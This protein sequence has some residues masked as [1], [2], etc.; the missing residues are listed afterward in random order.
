[1]RTAQEFEQLRRQATAPRLAG[2]SRREIKQV[3]GPISYRTLDKA[4]KEVPPAEWTRRPNAKDDLRARARELRLQGLDYD[5]IVSLRVT[6]SNSDPSLIR[7]FLCFLRIAGTADGDVKFQLQIHDSV[8]VPAAEAYWLRV[9]G[10]QPE[11]FRRTVLK[12]SN[13]QTTRRNTGAD[14]HGC[15]RIDVLQSGRLYLKIDGWAGA[16]MA[17][18]PGWSDPHDSH[19]H[20]IVAMSKYWTVRHA[21]SDAERAAAAAQF[22]DL[23]GRELLIAGAIAYWCEGSKRKPYRKDTQV[24]FINSDPR[25]ILLFLRF[26]TEAGVMPDRLRYCVHIH[27]SADVEAAISWWA[28]VA[29]VPPDQFARPVIKRHT[30][31]TAHR[32]ANHEYHG[33]LQI[34]VRKGAALYRQIAGWATGV[35]DAAP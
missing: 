27:E 33:C 7:L 2:K 1:M 6:F 17:C 20:A 25:L 22:S 10:A 4:L 9:T 3:L 34:R 28:S 29:G 18:A 26:L 32:E 31:R 16:I 11:Q 21:A 14:Y 12:R 35:M 19:E 13:P 23:T 5:E 30:P 15:L 24:S 8:D